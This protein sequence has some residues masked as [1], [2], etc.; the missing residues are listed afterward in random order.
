MRSTATRRARNGTLT[1]PTKVAST[2]EVEA[3]MMVAQRL[4]ASRDTVEKSAAAKASPSPTSA[5]R[6][7]TQT[8]AEADCSHCPS[9]FGMDGLGAEGLDFNGL[10]YVE[11]TS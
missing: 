8:S 9:R 2:S 4:P 1:S 6:N 3:R 11:P 10:A 7:L 5:S